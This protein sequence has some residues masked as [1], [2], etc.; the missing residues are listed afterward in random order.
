MCHY[1]QEIEVKCGNGEKQLNKA[2][3]QMASVQDDL[4]QLPEGHFECWWKQNTQICANT[5]LQIELIGIY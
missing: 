1:P 3:K 2:E 4:F 5:F